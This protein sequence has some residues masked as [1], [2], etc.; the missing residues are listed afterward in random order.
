MPLP[1]P[2][3]P[4]NSL[5]FPTSNIIFLLFKHPQLFPISNLITNVNFYFQTQNLFQKQHLFLIFTLISKQHIVPNSTLTSNFQIYLQPP[6]LIQTF[7]F[8]SLF[9][10]PTLSF[11]VS[12]TPQSKNT[13]ISNLNFHP[14]FQHPPLFSNHHTQS[15]LNYCW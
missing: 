9:P 10:I 1:T 4:P 3:V 12:P 11:K 2:I 5:L 14:H 6:Y 8:W 13:Y 7:T 15:I